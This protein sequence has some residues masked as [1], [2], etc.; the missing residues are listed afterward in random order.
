MTQ[1]NRVKH[2]IDAA[3][4]SPGRLAST[5]ATIL[6]GKNKPTYTPNIDDGDF[7]EVSNTAQMKWTG[8]KLDQKIYIHHSGYLGGLKEKPAR[9]VFE[10][11][12]DE[13]LQRAVTCMLPKNTFRTQRLLRLTFKR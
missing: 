8:K 1:I 2:Q 7:V 5:I 11:N 12:P 4:Q 13:V 10:D 9:K 6:I 3:G